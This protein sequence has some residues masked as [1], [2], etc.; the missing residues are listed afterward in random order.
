MSSSEQA[1]PPAA[2][3][4]ETDAELVAE[5]SQLVRDVSAEIAREAVLPGLKQALVGVSEASSRT[6]SRLEEKVRAL[7]EDDRRLL[8]EA[9]RDPIR[10]IVAAYE[11]AQ[12]TLASLASSSRLVENLQ[13]LAARLEELK[14][15]AEALE[16]QREQAE[17]FLL[18]EGRSLQVTI[19]ALDQRIPDVARVLDEVSK[20]REALRAV[21]ERT[22]LLV[23]QVRELVQQ[24]EGRLRAI[25]GISETIG[26]TRDRL[27]VL[28]EQVRALQEAADR[29]AASFHES[30]SK[31]FTRAEE[32]AKERWT[33]L[34]AR[35]DLAVDESTATAR[36]VIESLSVTRDHIAEHIEKSITAQTRQWTAALQPIQ[37]QLKEL[38]TTTAELQRH[39]SRYRVLLWVLVVLTVWMAIRPPVW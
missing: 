15:A 28:G 38:Q 7:L 20:N 14:T 8:Q 22:E 36:N 39:L 16:H 30:L 37:D 5:F 27:T 32:Q 10:D 24:V 13:L 18:E 17:R 29:N 4:Q 21:T 1:L 6:L 9:L 35:L 12:E 34:L 11:G 31:A 19:R 23:R 26:S 2:G 25:D 33:H 3:A